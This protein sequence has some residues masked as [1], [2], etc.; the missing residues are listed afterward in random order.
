[1]WVRSIIIFR[2]VAAERSSKFE[3]VTFI[4]VLYC[5]L[6]DSKVQYSALTELKRKIELPKREI[7][8]ERD[9]ND[10]TTCLSCPV[11]LVC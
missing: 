3:E 10:D 4:R 6:E 7:L 9:E 2:E 8:G 1:M 11:S 5:P